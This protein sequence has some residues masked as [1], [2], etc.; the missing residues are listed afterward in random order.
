MYIYKIFKQYGT[1]AVRS[2]KGL[3]NK[4]DLNFAFS[5]VRLTNN[6]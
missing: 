4:E 5:Q 1:A 3:K 2:F 6:Q